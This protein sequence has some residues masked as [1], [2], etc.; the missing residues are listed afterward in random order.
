MWLLYTSRERGSICLGCLA[1]AHVHTIRQARRS[2]P[3]PPSYSSHRECAMAQDHKYNGTNPEN[4]PPARIFNIYTSYIKNSILITHLS[5]H[6]HSSRLLPKLS[7]KIWDFTSLDI[8]EHMPSE[9]VM[10]R[11]DRSH[12]DQDPDCTPT[13]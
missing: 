8:R 9:L 11:P 7:L 13:W 10:N 1:A 6:L 2:E 3:Q 5:I 12:S 4:G